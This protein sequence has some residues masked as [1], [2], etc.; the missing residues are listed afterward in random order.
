MS[1][2]DH[3]PVLLRPPVSL[4]PWRY[5]DASLVRSV[6]TD[7]LIP[8]ITTVPTTGTYAD[9]VAYIDRQHDRLTAGEGYSFVVADPVSD[10]PVGN[11]GLW[12][13]NLARGRV[14]IGYWIAERYRRH[15]YAHAALAAVAAWAANLPGVA[16]MELFVEP[17]NE[18]SWRVAEANGFAREG[19]LRRWQRVGD[20]YRDMWVYSRL[21]DV[22]SPSV[23]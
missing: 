21:A 15:G 11:I 12:T 16:R 14:S 2:P 3:V 1:L 22:S 20:D 5:S 23:G 19:L 7:P 6:A 8:L 4:R 9:A 13:P 18:G 17:W 10:E